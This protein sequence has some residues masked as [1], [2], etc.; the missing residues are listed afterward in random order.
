MPS[1]Q[2]ILDSADNSAVEQF[3]GYAETI[4]RSYDG[5]EIPGEGQTSKGFRERRWT[6]YNQG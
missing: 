6:T 2:H 3:K 5:T 4:A 1:R